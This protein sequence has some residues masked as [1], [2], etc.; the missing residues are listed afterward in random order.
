MSSQSNTASSSGI[1]LSDVAPTP[2]KPIT[3]FSSVLTVASLASQFK[4]ILN[5]S[6]SNKANQSN[7]NK[8]ASTSLKNDIA[9]LQ[10]KLKSL[11]KKKDELH[12]SLSKKKEEPTAP[13][14]IAPSA[15]IPHVAHV[16]PTSAVEP[17]TIKKTRKK[18]VERVNKD[19]AVE[20]KKQLEPKEKMPRRKHVKSS[21]VAFVGTYNIKPDPS[22]HVNFREL[23]HN[24]LTTLC[25]NYN[26]LDSFIE[27][28]EPVY[29]EL[30]PRRS[31]A[32]STKDSIEEIHPAKQFLQQ[33]SSMCKLASI[34]HVFGKFPTI[35]LSPNAKD[36]QVS[37]TNEPHEKALP[38][39]LE[40]DIWHDIVYIDHFLRKEHLP[41]H[42]KCEL[43]ENKQFFKRLYIRLHLIKAGWNDKNIETSI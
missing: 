28:H 16:T 19:E 43:S 26:D 8:N 22:E 30:Y 21:E 41:P 4:G 36:L 2:P 13:V 25:E 20:E 37:E 15:P 18:A 23:V 40:L 9:S 1:K 31:L 38:E 33:C 32:S 27:H 6:S 3:S 24:E 34:K 39:T 11:S 42:I 35:T 7:S 5:S 14:L 29:D 10:D 17:K 12:Q